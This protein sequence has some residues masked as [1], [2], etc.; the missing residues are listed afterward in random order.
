M[1]EAVV[2]TGVGAEAD[3]D[4]ADVVATDDVAPVLLLLPPQATSPHIDATTPL[5][6]AVRAVMARLGMAKKVSPSGGVEVDKVIGC[7]GR[8][9]AC[10]TWG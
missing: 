8:A 9:L 1:S 6:S 5:A 7:T 4:T 2:A 10:R 3:G